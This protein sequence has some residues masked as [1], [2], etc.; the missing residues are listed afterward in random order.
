LIANR[1]IGPPRR[2]ARTVDHSST[3]HY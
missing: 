3:A 1:D 2:Q